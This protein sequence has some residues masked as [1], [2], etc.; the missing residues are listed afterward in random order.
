MFWQTDGTN[1]TDGHGQSLE[2]LSGDF[3]KV[4]V[5]VVTYQNKEVKEPTTIFCQKTVIFSLL[6]VRSLQMFCLP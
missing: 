2:E 4:E 1:E 6:L 5:L 3:K